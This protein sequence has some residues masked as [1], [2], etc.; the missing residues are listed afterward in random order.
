MARSKV[1]EIGLRPTTCL[2]EFVSSE[3]DDAV[4]AFNYYDM[5]Y[6]PQMERVLS[7]MTK[8]QVFSGSLRRLFAALVLDI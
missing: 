7:C 1:L 5:P 2:T 3:A 4:L 8:P 6:L